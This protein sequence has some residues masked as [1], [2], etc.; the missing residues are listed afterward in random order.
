MKRFWTAVSVEP[1]ETGGHGL[2]LDGRPVRT[3]GRLPLILPSTALAE[4]IADEWRAVDGEIDPREMKLTGPANAAIERVAPA[5][6]GFA[7]DLAAYGETDLLC[8]RAEGP[9]ALV[10]RQQAAWDPLLDWARR[11]YDIGFTLVTGVIHRPQPEETV[12]RLA[13]AV[14]ARDPFRLAGLSPI[15]TIGGSLIAALALEDCATDAETVW[16]ATQLDELWQAEIWG[17]DA[18]AAKARGQRRADFDAAARFLDL[19]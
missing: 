12:R 15:V 6:S 19:L 10:A 1:D 11:R 2:R 4:A 18:L 7:A 13:E 17:E 8:Y 3:P 5:A 9:A 14:A 16:Q